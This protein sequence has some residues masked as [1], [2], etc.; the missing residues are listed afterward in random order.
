M[1]IQV[2]VVD[3][4]EMVRKGV[5]SLLAG[6]GV[7]ICGEAASDEEALRQAKKFQPDVVLLDVRLGPVSG[8]GLIKRIRSAAPDARVVMLTA[9]DNPAYVAQ[10]LSEGAHDLW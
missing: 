7:R 4:H 10:A 1:A 2:L 5:A 9:F 8:I 6:T 3:D